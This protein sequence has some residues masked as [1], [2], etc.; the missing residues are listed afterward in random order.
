M[1]NSHRVRLRGGIGRSRSCKGVVKGWSKGRGVDEKT[2]VQDAA[3][4]L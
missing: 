3:F 1:I 4:I 2:G